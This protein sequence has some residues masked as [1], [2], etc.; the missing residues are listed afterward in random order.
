M[1][2]TEGLCC[3]IPGLQLVLQMKKTVDYL[4]QNYNNWVSAFKI[5]LTVMAYK[6]VLRG[7]L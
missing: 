7:D 1:S 2:F 3:Q 5:P 6:Y 4:S